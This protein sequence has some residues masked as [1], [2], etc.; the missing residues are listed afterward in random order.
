MTP[1]PRCLSQWLILSLWGWTP[2]SSFC[3][4]LSL[5]ILHIPHLNLVYALSRDRYH[6][7]LDAYSSL[8]SFPCHTISLPSLLAYS[9]LSPW[10]FPHNL[11]KWEG[12][13]RR[14]ERKKE[15]REGGGGE[16]ST[17]VATTTLHLSYRRRELLSLSFLRQQINYP[18]SLPFF[19]ALVNHGFSRASL[20]NENPH[21]W[22]H[23]FIQMSVHLSVNDISGRPASP[24]NSVK[25]I[26]L[27]L[28]SDSHVSL[29][30]RHGFALSISFP[31][32][33]GISCQFRITE[34]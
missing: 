6:L 33:P 31:S 27:L 4:S 9:W 7:T 10:W 15:E 16:V 11:W 30:S 29:L 34:R 26:V 14:N 20:I 5:H 8:I 19:S 2:C 12:V 1:S 24:S 22:G 17:F 21:R 28:Q 18:L 32:F 13:V 25:G 3:F 23:L